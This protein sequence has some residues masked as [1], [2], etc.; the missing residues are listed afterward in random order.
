[1]RQCPR[2]E[3]VY[4]SL[5]SGVEGGRAI[6][7]N[8]LSARRLALGVMLGLEAGRLVLHGAARGQR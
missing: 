7:S 8:A 3:A 1:M 2:F 5:G 4:L 6:V